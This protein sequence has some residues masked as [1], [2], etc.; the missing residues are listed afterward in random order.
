[1]A[2]AL[3]ATFEL[4]GLRHQRM[5]QA[6]QLEGSGEGAGDKG[7]KGGIMKDAAGANKEG[8]KAEAKVVVRTCSGGQ[9]GITKIVDDFVPR[10]MQTL[11]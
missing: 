7:K 6:E 8:D 9:E 5:A 3:A 10:A 2:S 4:F 1:M 11:A